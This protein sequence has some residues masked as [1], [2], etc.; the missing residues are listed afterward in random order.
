MGD[1]VR[2]E[3]LLLRPPVP[4]D[5]ARLLELALDPVQLAYGIPVGVPLPHTEDDLD[6]RVESSRA[7]YALREPGDLVIT[8]EL[9]ESR[10]L[11]TVGWRFDVPAVLRVADVGYA[12]HSDARGRGV[13]GRALRVAVRWLLLDDAGPRLA[14]V[15]L[16]HSVDNP[17]SCRT[18]LAAGMER[19]GTRR[20]FLPLRGESG[21]PRRH[22]VCLH[23]VLPADL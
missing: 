21:V 17:A 5:R 15:Q 12:V 13:A 19:E 6:Q 2:G 18:A 16:D 11:G 23:G 10:A 20:G 14:R 4:A 3:G 8:E 7:A 1:G 22:D 9:D